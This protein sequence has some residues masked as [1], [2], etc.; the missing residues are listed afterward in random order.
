[1]RDCPEKYRLE[2]LEREPFIPSA[3]MIQGT[4]F[5]RTYEEWEKSGRQINVARKYVENFDTEVSKESERTPIS[6][7]KVYGRGRDVMADISIRRDTGTQQIIDYSAYCVETRLSLFELPNGEPAVE[8]PFS[9]NLGGVEVIGSVDC[10]IDYGND[11]LTV[12]DLKT[13]GREASGFQLGLYAE[14]LR[15]AL[16]LDIILGEFYY[17]KDNTLSEPI[18]LRNFTNEYLTTQ[19]KAIDTIINNRAF[20][21]HPTS[22]CFTCG[23]RSKCREFKKA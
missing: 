14:A 19:V 17:A 20:M 5:H 2:R 3:A 8:V 1:M 22:N 13:G 10:V 6:R 12:R 4:A 15:Q 9:I 21:P 7:W 23:V 11:A 16:G 18:D